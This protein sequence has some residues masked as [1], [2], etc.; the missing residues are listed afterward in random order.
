MTEAASED[1]PVTQQSEEGSQ[2]IS[3][4]QN[5]DLKEGAGGRICDFPAVSDSPDE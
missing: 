2:G 3:S 5:V 4:K 1:I